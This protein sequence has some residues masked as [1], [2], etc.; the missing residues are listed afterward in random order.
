MVHF[1]FNLDAE[2]DI[3]KFKE[4]FKRLPQL[5]MFSKHFNLLE[6]NDFSTFPCQTCLLKQ[7]FPFLFR[8]TLVSLTCCLFTELIS[9]VLASS[10]YSFNSNQPTNLASWKLRYL[11]SLCFLCPLLACPL[12]RRQILLARNANWQN[13]GRISEQIAV[14]AYSMRGKHLFSSH[15]SL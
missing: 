8:K 7:Y 2:I 15:F 10:L 14:F 11:Y 1:L 12:Y 9:S 5:L 3:E 6:N 4:N 13:Y